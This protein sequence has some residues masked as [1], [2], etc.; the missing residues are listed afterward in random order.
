[1]P[2]ISSSSKTPHKTDKQGKKQSRPSVPADEDPFIATSAPK[3]EDETDHEPEQTVKRESDAA[4][5]TEPSSLNISDRPVLRRNRGLSTATSILSGSP[6]SRDRPDGANNQP[7]TPSRAHSRESQEPLSRVPGIMLTPSP[8]TTPETPISSILDDNSEVSQADGLETPLTS[9]SSFSPSPNPSSTVTND[10][11]PRADP[12]NDKD[13]AARKK[14]KSR[15]SN[16]EERPSQADSVESTHVR[17]RCLNCSS[18]LPDAG[19]ETL[20]TPESTRRSRSSR[21]P[22]VGASPSRIRISASNKGLDDL[23]IENGLFQDSS[24]KPQNFDKLIK[25]L[26]KPRE[27][28]RVPK[29]KFEAF[30]EE[31]SKVDSE[32]AARSVF[33]RY[34][35]HESKVSCKEEVS[36]KVRSLLEP[37]V[38]V[39]KP[40]YCDGEDPEDL[41]PEVRTTF[42]D[43]IISSCGTTQRAL[44]NYF[45]EIKGPGGKEDVA[46]RQAMYTGAI[47]ARATHDIRCY[48]HSKTCDDEVV[49]SI[50]ATYMTPKRRGILKLY[51]VYASTSENRE[52]SLDYHMVKLRSLAVTDSLEDFRKGIQAM[53]NA[54]EWAEDLRKGYV[55]KANAKVEK[56]KEEDE[57]EDEEEEDKEEE[58]GDDEND[59]DD[60]DEEEECDD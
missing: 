48:I 52:D 30:K 33:M 50:T 21:S 41:K 10:Y 60:D 13:K 5:S 53:E 12:E 6:E 18:P 46:R 9:Q 29:S 32:A 44:A 54:R 2:S 15:S 34:F 42:R 40:D 55:K 22:S 24:V 39:F 49:R 14:A 20:Q 1:M 59:E 43:T 3:P 36:F 38:G 58:E 16:I 35:L 56:E 47:G 8:P 17:G 57:E 37:G 26:S 7:V 19:R 23:F 25:I 31:S 11:F 27:R 4:P 45:I 51:A 28:L